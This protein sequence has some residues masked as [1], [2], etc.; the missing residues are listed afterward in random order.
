MLPS[1]GIDLNSATVE[2]LADLPKIG[3]SRASRLVDARPFRSWEDVTKVPAIGAGV[4][5]HL[6]RAGVRIR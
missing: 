6:K 5:Q 1:D 4:V 2:Q 3:E